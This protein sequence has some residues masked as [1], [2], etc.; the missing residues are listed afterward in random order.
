MNYTCYI[1]EYANGYERTFTNQ[2]QL[3]RELRMTRKSIYNGF[4]RGSCAI[5]DIN[6]VRVI[7]KC[8]GTVVEQMINSDREIYK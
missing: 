2:E 8:Y 6:I 7:R 3:T 4:K 5:K 1:V